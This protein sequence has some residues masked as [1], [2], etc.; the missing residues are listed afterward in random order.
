MIITPSNV[1][2]NF[3]WNNQNRLRKF[4]KC[5]FFRLIMAA[6]LWHLEQLVRNFALYSRTTQGMRMQ[7]MI[8]IS[9]TLRTIEPAQMYAQILD[10][11]AVASNISKTYRQTLHVGPN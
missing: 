2:A 8:G 6:I 11:A 10:P 7:N 1:P 5:D 3:L 9:V 4:K